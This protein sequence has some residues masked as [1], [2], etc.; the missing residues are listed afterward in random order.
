MATKYVVET[1]NHYLV[2]NEDSTTDFTRNIRN[3]TLFDYEDDAIE[4]LEDEVQGQPDE[5][6]EDYKVIGLTGEEFFALMTK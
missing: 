3:A 1:D 6:R 2:V 4:A 5:V